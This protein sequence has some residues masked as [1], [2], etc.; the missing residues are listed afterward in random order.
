MNK[1]LLLAAYDREHLDD[2][3]ASVE[4]TKAL[5]ESCELQCER[6]ILQKTQ[7]SS[8]TYIQKGKLDE[9]L[10]ILETEEIATV[11]T[12]HALSPSQHRN[13]SVALGC[14]VLDRT[15]IILEIFNRRATSKEAKLEVEH[16]RL[17]Y[18]LPHTK[19]DFGSTGR[20]QGGAFRTRGAGEQAFQLRQRILE[21]TLL[22]LDKQLDLIHQNTQ[23]QIIR[24]QKQDIFTIAIIGYTN[25]GKS[26]LMNRFLTQFSS[27]SGKQ[28][29]AKDQVFESLNTAARRLS[30][31]GR[32]MV[33]ID[34][35]GFVSDLPDDLM[36]AFHATLTSIQHADLIL[37]IVD[38][39]SPHRDKQSQVTLD[40]LKTLQCENITRLDVFN[41]VDLVNEACVGI[42]AQSGLNFETLVQQI[43][44]IYDDMRP[45]VLIELPY[46]QQDDLRHIEENYSYT[47]IRNL[48]EG[49]RIRLHH[50]HEC[51]KRLMA[52][53]IK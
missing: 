7:G 38:A 46:Q 13:L 28:V 22:K 48:D 4:E 8:T 11:V 2:F 21:K 10:T 6:T 34:T 29:S 37:H 43:V 17:S 49:Y 9:I 50:I 26:T 39:S 14:E 44:D 3:Q 5:I 52:Y 19:L 27:K 15:Q 23:R 51:P 16:A 31:D 45:N 25:A 32:D 53:H 24:R 18:L 47:M 20:Q 41:K 30:I 36:R 35:V 12:H 42:S 1:V 40:T 33:M